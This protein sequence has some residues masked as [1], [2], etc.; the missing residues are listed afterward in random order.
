MDLESV[1]GVSV[2]G[3]A[4]GIRHEPVSNLSMKIG[5]GGAVQSIAWNP[6][7]GSSL[8]FKNCDLTLSSPGICGSRNR[9]YG[10]NPVPALNTTTCL[11]SAS[12][13]L[14][15]SDQEQSAV[16]RLICLKLSIGELMVS[17]YAVS[18]GLTAESM[19]VGLTLRQRGLSKK[20]IDR[21][22]LV[23]RLHQLT[24]FTSLDGLKNMIKHG[25]LLGLD[26]SL[27]AS[28]VESYQEYVH[29][30][31]CACIMGK[32]RAPSALVYDNES[33]YRNT[34][35]CD[36]FQ[37]TTD[38][39]KTLYY[40]FLGVDIES[41][42]VF[43]ERIANSSTQ[44]LQRA[45]TCVEALYH[46]HK[47]KLEGIVMDNAGGLISKHMKDFLCRRGLLPRYATT[48]LHV[49]VAEASVKI[50][51]SLCRTTVLDW[52]TSRKFITA[53][54]PYL[55]TWV[56]QSINFCLRNGTEF[57]SPHLRFTKVPI[58]MEVHLRYAFLDTV[59][60]HKTEST[61]ISNLESKGTVGLVVARDGDAGAM[62]V[63]NL[64][65]YEG[66]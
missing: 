64:K 34:C 12:T 45:V 60:F 11:V 19:I 49:R 6:E 13:K 37:L 36:V 44:E 8:T 32:I 38:D 23:G 46:R 30:L 26:V 5:G 22:A 61:S 15:L 51:K 52:S 10:S 17:W 1:S 48:G 40:F 56:T 50:V 4:P 33:N 53:F 3:I 59:A 47:R 18:E 14:N 42:Y 63:L 27:T 16:L 21:I 35:F 55:V 41:Q 2:K 28:D 24:S 29:Q 9:V 57:A 43:T 7:E 66:M 39:K 65:K 54:V 62:T 58:K 20:A 25:L 31:D